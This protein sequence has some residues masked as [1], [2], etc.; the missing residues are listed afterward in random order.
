VLNNRF[1]LL[2]VVA[3][4]FLLS[5]YG[6]THSNRKFKLLLVGFY[7]IGIL[8]NVGYNLDGVRMHI[9]THGGDPNAINYQIVNIVKQQ[10]LTKGYAPYWS[11]QIN[12]YLSPNH[13]QFLPVTCLGH[14]LYKLDWVINEPDFNIKAQR[15]FFLYSNV[16]AWCNVSILQLHP[17]KVIPIN[18]TYTLY[19]FNSD[20]G[21]GLKSHDL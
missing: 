6:F 14:T 16:V 1:V 10:G 3:Q 17:V 20:I 4:I 5:I 9:H 7:A 2:A 21:K 13:A 18:N 8:L 12:T 11:A 19:I 15:S